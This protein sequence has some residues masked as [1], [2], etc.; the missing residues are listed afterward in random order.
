M[1]SLIARVHNESKS[2]AMKELAQ[3]VRTSEMSFATSSTNRARLREGPFVGV[4]MYTN[5]AT[6][7]D[8]FFAS[9]R[10]RSRRQHDTP[11]CLLSRRTATRCRLDDDADN[12]EKADGP[13]WRRDRLRVSARPT[14]L[15]SVHNLSVT[16]APT[17]RRACLRCRWVGGTCASSSDASALYIHDGANVVQWKG[18]SLPSLHNTLLLL[19]SASSEKCLG[20]IKSGDSFFH[21][22]SLSLSLSLLGFLPL[23]FLPAPP[24]R[25]WT[26]RDWSGTFRDPDIRPPQHRGAGGGGG[27]NGGTIRVKRRHS[28][29]ARSVRDVRD[30]WYSLLKTHALLLVNFNLS[31]G[32]LIYVRDKEYIL[33]PLWCA[34]KQM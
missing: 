14:Y 32:F 34:N 2:Q 30:C 7:R 5:L 1:T 3:L 33:S 6:K 29:E 27:A 18:S 12:F 17:T 8:A 28:A 15:N 16:R 10:R 24:T 4:A 11:V 23:P 25:A 9:R 20:W 31:N 19:T 21:L 26:G 13:G 22:L